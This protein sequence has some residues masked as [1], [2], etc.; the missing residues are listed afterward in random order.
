MLATARLGPK[1]ATL[2][3]AARGRVGHAPSAAADAE[4]ERSALDKTGIVLRLASHLRL[5]NYLE[6]CTPLSGNYYR[7][8]HCHPALTARRLMYRCGRF[9]SDGLPVDYRS[10]DDDIAAPLAQLRRD[11]FEV[12]LCLVDGWHDYAVTLRDL[13]AAFALLPRG[14]AL[15]VHDCLPPS[16]EM[17]TA[18]PQSGCWCGLTYR[19]FIDFV[20]SEPG[21]S[22]FTVD[23]DYGCGVILKGV[24]APD[25]VPR[26][27][28]AAEAAALED[29]RALGDDDAAAFACLRQHKQ[30]LLRLVS[31]EAF[32]AACGD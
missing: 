1:L 17:A 5:R 28:P 6:L 22:F 2:W 14:G 26:P 24:P 8:L 13:R 21:L 9:R 25:F 12:E 32:M 7:R 19:A 20:R 4:V 27:T 16:A 23:C 18:Q 30:A 29:W 10:P 11:G 3:W 31:A 15:V